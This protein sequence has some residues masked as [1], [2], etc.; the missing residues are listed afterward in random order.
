[1][2][3]FVSLKEM[4]LANGVPVS[5]GRNI[6]EKGIIESNYFDGTSLFTRTYKNDLLV[7]GA[8]Y[9][10][11]KANNVRAEY[12]PTSIDQDYAVIGANV[13]RNLINLGQENLI[14]I[15]VGNGGAG[16][17]GSIY[18]VQLHKKT[19]PG[20]VPFRVVPISEDLTGTERTKYFMRVVDGSLIYYYGKRFE[21]ANLKVLYKNG[22]EVPLNVGLLDQADDIDVYMEYTVPVST[23]DIREYSILTNGDTRLSRVNSL[24][25][26]SGF[27]ETIDGGLTEYRNIRGVTVSNMDNHPLKDNLSFINFVYRVYLK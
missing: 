4:I 13:T 26:L 17:S 24:G 1:M 2:K 23:K 21:S 22:T 16:L 7:T 3:D 6:K 15:M 8:L 25:I 12:Q 10:L 9:F 27:P 20:L 5:A 19:V 14:G 11:E 18:E